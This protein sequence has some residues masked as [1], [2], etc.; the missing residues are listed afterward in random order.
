MLYLG[1]PLGAL[2]LGRAGLVP[3][4]A[5]IG[6]PD[7]PGM[8]R[9]RRMMAEAR[10]LLLG[11][12][13]LEAPAVRKVLESACID[14]ILSWFWPRRV[15]AA[16]LA[17]APRGAWGVHPSL[18]PRWRGPD[19]YFWAIRAGDRETG[20]TL[21]R[22]TERYDAGEIVEQIRVPV[23][24]DDDAWSLARRLDRPALDLLVRCAQRLARGECLVGAPQDEDA[25]SWARRPEPDDLVIDWRR[26]AEEIERLV[27]AAAP[28]P[29]ASARLGETPVDVLAVRIVDGRRLPRA[30][31]PGEAWVEPDD[32]VLVRCG[33]GGAIRLERVRV[34]SGQQFA[35]PAIA[36]LLRAQG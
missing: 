13:D 18:L 5:C 8:R 19:P 36:N 23:R 34:A 26:A 22:L 14:V 35:G 25:V 28:E 6:H 21:H 15:P 4:V 17:L 20:V 11:A 30:L 33:D 12:P 24:S 32:G 9:S 1:L 16:V 27:R 7:A 2:A 10:A 31:K 29:G 3:S